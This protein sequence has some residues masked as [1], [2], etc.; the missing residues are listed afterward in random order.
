M[1]HKLRFYL[2][3]LAI[4]LLAGAMRF[5]RLDLCIWQRDHAEEFS[6]ALD[7]I[8]NGH[9]PMRSL[10]ASVGRPNPPGLTWLVAA[11][12]AIRPTPLFATGSV[13]LL[14]TL[15]VWLTGLLGRRLAGSRAG[16]LAAALLAVCPW[17]VVP[18][19]GVWAPNYL[20]FFSSL[21]MWLLFHWMRRPA[22]PWIIAASWIALFMPQIHFS[23]VAI[24]P[25]VAYAGWVGLR[26]S[27]ASIQRLAIIGIVIVAGAAAFW[28]P[29]FIEMRRERD[30]A[31]YRK[32]C[33][34]NWFEHGPRVDPYWRPEK[35]V[36]RLLLPPVIGDTLA[37]H[38]ADFL[39]YWVGDF[40]E[41]MAVHRPLWKTY[42][43]IA[44]F[45]LLV[46]AMGAAGFGRR[47]RG[48]RSLRQ[49]MALFLLLWLI[50]PAV[51][52][53]G[54]FNLNFPHY[55]TIVHPAGFLLMARHAE[56]ARRARGARW[57][58]RDFRMLLL[59]CMAFGLVVLISLASDLKGSEG[60]PEG[61]YGMTYKY[62]REHPEEA[63]SIE[64]RL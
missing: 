16:L 61:Y 25:A 55:F 2:P 19:R 44:S 37:V 36:S 38:S 34:W 30:P 27:N 10:D 51:F 3:L 53:C 9:F 45:A 57:L 48:A 14:N 13:A 32:E 21:S 56:L 23:P 5:W 7:W 39:E 31:V 1:N 26:R 49:R 6:R 42:G 18:G 64:S 60:F 50:L 28:A 11:A 24:L 47:R 58:E 22:A 4:V 20:P 40:E 33:S 15:A 54:R 41:T 52:L 59:A 63:P 12:A 62:M 29:Y 35:P 43:V 46:A 17:V 8:Q